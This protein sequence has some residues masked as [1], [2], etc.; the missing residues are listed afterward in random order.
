[1]LIDAV[2]ERGSLVTWRKKLGQHGHKTG[3]AKTA[4]CTS[5]W[6]RADEPLLETQG[7]VCHSVT[8]AFLPMLL[9]VK[10]LVLQP[11]AKLK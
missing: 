9:E 7:S 10:F 5:S 11:R 8:W 1:M 3:R 6:K 2:K 4:E